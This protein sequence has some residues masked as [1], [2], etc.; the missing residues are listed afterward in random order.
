MSAFQVDAEFSYHF[1]DDNWVIPHFPEESFEDFDRQRE[2]RGP[3]CT[4][5]IKSNLVAHGDKERKIHAVASW[6]RD[7]LRTFHKV[8]FFYER[9]PFTP[10]E[11][12]DFKVG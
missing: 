8:N 9:T 5:A 7:L 2:D 10:A 4:C 3:P 1:F 6:T 12:E 11:S